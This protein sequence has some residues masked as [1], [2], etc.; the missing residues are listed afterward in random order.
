MQASSM[1][2]GHF[3]PDAWCSIMLGSIPG[4][5]AKAPS[6]KKVQ[7]PKGVQS[8]TDDLAQQIYQMRIENQAL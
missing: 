2:N 6:N 5:L 7:A 4:L 8:T 1:A 3:F